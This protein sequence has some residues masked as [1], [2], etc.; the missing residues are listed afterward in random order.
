MG[1]FFMAFKK[2]FNEGKNHAKSES[3]RRHD[4][5]KIPIKLI[6]PSIG[7][8][9]QIEV[10]EQNNRLFQMYMAMLIRYAEGL[11]KFGTDWTVEGKIIQIIFADVDMAESVR[12]TLKKWHYQ[13]ATRSL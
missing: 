10:I 2:G 12:Q 9:V 3:Y 13:I 11:K 4:R 5:P 1:N 6:E 7:R 8:I